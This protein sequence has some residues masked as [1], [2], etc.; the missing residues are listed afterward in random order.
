MASP[1]TVKRL[2]TS[3]SFL[4]GPPVI[5]FEGIAVVSGISRHRIERNV[6]KRCVLLASHPSSETQ[7]GNERKRRREEEAAAGSRITVELGKKDDE[8]EED[9][10]EEDEDEEERHDIKWLNFL[11]LNYHKQ[12]SNNL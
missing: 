10:E 1:S 8:E 9:D 4:L 7:G 12:R 6:A 5:G 11:A 3:P 2:A